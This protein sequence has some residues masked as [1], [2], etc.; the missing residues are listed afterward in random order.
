MN[1]KKDVSGNPLS[2]AFGFQKKPKK[3]QIIVEEIN[4]WQ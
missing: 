4:V 3:G 1:C 2:G